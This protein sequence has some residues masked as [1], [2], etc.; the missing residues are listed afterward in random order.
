MLFSR[1]YANSSPFPPPSLPPSPA[2]HRQAPISPAEFARLFPNFRDFAA[3]Y[4]P[5]RMNTYTSL[6]KQTTLSICRTI[7]LQKS[8][9]GGQLWLTTPIHP[10]PKPATGAAPLRPISATLIRQI[11]QV[12]HHP[13][14]HWRIAANSY[15][16]A[17]PK[18]PRVSS[19]PLAATISA[20]LDGLH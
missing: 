8:G 17:Q 16:L 15:R 9:V 3:A 6:S 2:R 20:T 5:F 12:S 10:S 1:V 18:R 14:T 4:N 7:D 19:S 13:R 11:L